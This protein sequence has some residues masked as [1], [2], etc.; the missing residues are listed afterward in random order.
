MIFFQPMVN[1]VSHFI[2]LESD[3]SLQSETPDLEGQVMAQVKSWTAFTLMFM[4]LSRLLKM[5][6][7]SQ[8]V[9]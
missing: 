9:F 4:Y 2:F 1:R 6:L 3:S 7:P 8:A 5:C